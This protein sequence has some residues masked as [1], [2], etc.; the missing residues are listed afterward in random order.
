MRGT[1]LSGDVL[2]LSDGQLLTELGRE[3]NKIEK[4]VD[5]LAN[6]TLFLAVSESR[7]TRVVLR[8]VRRLGRFRVPSQTLLVRLIRHTPIIKHNI[9]MKI[10]REKTMLGWRQ[11]K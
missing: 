10:V 2:F 7:K 9:E 6:I 11:R 1:A 8:L 4:G 3:Q 5:V